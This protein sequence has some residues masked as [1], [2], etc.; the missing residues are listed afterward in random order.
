MPERLVKP[1]IPPDSC[2]HVDRVIEL[3]ENLVG[4]MDADIRNGYTNIIKEEME[5]VRTINTQ[6]RTASKFWHDKHR[7]K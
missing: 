5:M 6:L 2:D 1:N 4:E 3:A 7:K